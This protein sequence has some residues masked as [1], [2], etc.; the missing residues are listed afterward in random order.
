MHVGRCGALSIYVHGALSIYVHIAGAHEA[1][2]D[3][4]RG[5]RAAQ[6]LFGD[7]GKLV[8]IVRVLRA[9]QE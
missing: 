4:V 7:V 9:L 8:D 3:D 1:P 5:K 2:S 6:D